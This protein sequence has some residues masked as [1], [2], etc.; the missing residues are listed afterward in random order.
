MKNLPTIKT[1]SGEGTIEQLWISELGYLMLRFYHEN[2]SRWI[3]Y[4]LGTYNPED[5]VFTRI[6]DDAKIKI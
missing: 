3:T 6:I 2:E 4:N 1:S 5:N